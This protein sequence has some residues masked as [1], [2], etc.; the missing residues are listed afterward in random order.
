MTNSDSAWR[1]WGQR[2]AYYGVLSSNEYRSSNIDLSTKDTFFRTG[3]DVVRKFIDHAPDRGKGKALDFGCGVG[4]LVVPLAAEFKQVV[5]VDI[6]EHAMEE[7]ARNCTE[8]G[9]DNVSFVKSD[10][11]LSAVQGR[12]FDWVQSF[13]CIQHIRRD[14]GLRIAERLL[15][16]CAPGGWA[17]LHF[18]L[19][20]RQS[21]SRRVAYYV[22]HQLPGGAA[23]VNVFTG[24][25][26]RDPPMRME[27]YDP[28]DILE[29]FAA[30][31]FGPVQVF[32][33]YHGTS[34]TG[35]F[36]A[37]RKVGVQ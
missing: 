6:S 14:R 4:R 9:V 5:G 27:D 25:P 17:V 3:E 36:M 21:L 8:R 18:S 22:R 26:L 23:L 16:I 19:R 33:E 34:L 7:A 1:K 15:S 37:R 24:R 11:E 12:D 35:T 30:A 13:I 28:R 2:D 10:D 29:R 20:R 31:G 32:V